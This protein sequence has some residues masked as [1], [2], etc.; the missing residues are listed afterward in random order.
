MAAL[1]ELVAEK[2]AP[3][4]LAR[5]FAGSMVRP[6]GQIG[7]TIESGWIVLRDDAPIDG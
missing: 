7:G 5:E 2:E 4:P 1:A 3:E 6:P